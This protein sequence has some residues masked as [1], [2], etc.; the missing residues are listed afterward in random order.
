[1]AL[2]KSASLATVADQ[3]SNAPTADVHPQSIPS[4]KRPLVQ[5]VGLTGGTQVALMDSHCHI[6]LNSVTLVSPVAVLRLT[7]LN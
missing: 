1:M 5:M 6:N 2:A 7:V 3:A 4:L